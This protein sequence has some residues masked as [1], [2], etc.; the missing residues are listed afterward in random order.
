MKY[1]HFAELGVDWGA[2]KAIWQ[3][4]RNV[5]MSYRTAKQGATCHSFYPIGCV[6]ELR[7]SRLYSAAT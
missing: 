5:D 7:L 1:L 6:V 3:R 2:V 4:L